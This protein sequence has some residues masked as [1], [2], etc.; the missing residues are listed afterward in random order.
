VIN[1]QSVVVMERCIAAAGSGRR[2]AHSHLLR[3]PATCA[4]RH[5]GRW[6]RDEL[7]DNGTP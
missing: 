4:A 2:A 3:H 7:Y 1:P 6:S 5:A